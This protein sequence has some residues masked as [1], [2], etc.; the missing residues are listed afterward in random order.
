MMQES[1]DEFNYPDWREK[2]AGTATIKPISDEVLQRLKHVILPQDQWT[3]VDKALYGVSD[4]YY[5]DKE[6]AESLRWEA[7]KYAF[8]HH[9]LHNEFYRRYCKVDGVTPGDIISPSDL[10]KIPLIPDTFFKDY[11]Q[12]EGFI[13]WLG[14]IYTGTLPEIHLR[15][16]PSFQDILEALDEKGVKVTFTS[17]TTGRF[18]FFPRGQLTWKRQQYSI[19]NGV[20]DVFGKGYDPDR[21]FMAFTPNPHKTYLYLGRAQTVIYDALFSQENIHYLV[22]RKMTPDSIRISRGMARGPKEIL[23]AKL[24]KHVQKR[25]VSRFVR[26]LETFATEKR[27]IVLAGTPSLIESIVNQLEQE[28]KDLSFNRMLLSLQEEDGNLPVE[29]L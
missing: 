18:S 17:G 1:G 3:P 26:K 12:G 19:A 29:P 28:G 13:E 21:I 8:S 2:M 15:K 23:M 22:D 11:P 14:K 10:T 16:N 4:L 6:E 9:Y 7:I 5:V 20:M 24:A 27:P 25:L